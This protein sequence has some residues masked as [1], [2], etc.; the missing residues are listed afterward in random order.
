[1]S[2]N[3]HRAIIIFTTLF[4]EEVM[5]KKSGLENFSVGIQIVLSTLSTE[6]TLTDDIIIT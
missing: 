6:V 2:K 1:M 5:F 3:S 4:V